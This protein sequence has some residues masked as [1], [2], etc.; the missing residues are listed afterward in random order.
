V[1]PHVS[2]RMCR[3]HVHMF[4]KLRRSL[5]FLSIGKLEEEMQSEPSPETGSHVPPCS[6][7]PIVHAASPLL[8]RITRSN[9]LQ[10]PW[11]ACDASL[12]S[13]RHIEASTVPYG[14]D[15]R[16]IGARFLA[17]VRACSPQ[18]PDRIRS[19][20]SFLRHRYRGLF[21]RE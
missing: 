5:H 21:L 11:A 15:D 7:L 2:T 3:L 1:V 13:T 17:G 20:P 19:P 16:G 12:G 14:L 4:P 18:L 10:L 8:L 6:T 9:S